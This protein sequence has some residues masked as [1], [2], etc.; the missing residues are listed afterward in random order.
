MYLLLFVPFCVESIRLIIITKLYI[1]LLRTLFHIFGSMFR[2]WKNTFFPKLLIVIHNSVQ[3][4]YLS[5][6]R[7]KFWLIK[8]LMHFRLI[9]LNGRNNV[10]QISFVGYFIYAETSWPRK[11]GQTTR[12][13]GG[14][15]S[16]IKCMRFYYHMYGRHIA[17]L[18]IYLSEAGMQ[19]Y[20]WGRYKNQGNTWR[21]SNVTVFGNNYTVRTSNERNDDDK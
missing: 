16:G 4:T 19:S 14:P 13:I 3:L 7:A 6:K 8:D 9:M 21:Y 1:L 5:L 18:Q 17:D 15:F 11:S 2:P 12:L 10:K 20:I